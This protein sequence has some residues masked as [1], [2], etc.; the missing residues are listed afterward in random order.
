[1]EMKDVTEKLEQLGKLHQEFKDAHSKELADMKKNVT[2]AGDRIE[3]TEKLNEEIQKLNDQIRDIKAAATRGGQGGANETEEQKKAKE[4][5]AAFAAYLGGKKS[6]NELKSFNIEGNEDGGF[7]VTPEMSTEI[8]KKI[9]ETSP[10]RE[11]CSVQT[12]S[13]DQF[14]ILEDLEEMESGWVGEMASR[15]VTDNSK[16]KKIMIPVH[17]IYAQPQAT[18]KS[19]DDA[20]LNLESYIAEKVSDKFS[21][22]EATAFVAGDGVT[23]PKGILAYGAGDGFG[24]IERINSGHASQITADGVIDL[25]YAIKP[26]YAANAK[27]LMKRATEKAVRKLKDTQGRY[28]WEP[29]LNGKSQATLLGFPIYQ[30]NDLEDVAANAQAMIFGDFKQGYQIVDRVGIRILRDVYSAKP[31]VLFYTTK[32]VGGGVK[33][34]EALKIMKIAA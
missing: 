6:A 12:I 21:R 5:R 15:P 20:A 32:R 22:Q 13:S 1:M 16:F 26:A 34:F 18:Q 31:Y 33:N 28:L 17:E 4:S 2:A 7:L 14:E 9:F 25:T 3:K 29:G 8:V 11:I 10:M 23:K 24:L 30:A 27:F 19:L